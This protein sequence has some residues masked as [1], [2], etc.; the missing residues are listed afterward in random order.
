VADS[1]QP[2]LELTHDIEDHAVVSSAFLERPEGGSLGKLGDERRRSRV[3]GRAADPEIA[4]WLERQG[5]PDRPRGART[6][7]SLYAE[8][9]GRDPTETVLV[10]FGD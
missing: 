9:E 7:A 4:E 2:R 5:L 6:L 10:G 8:L 3:A 1:W